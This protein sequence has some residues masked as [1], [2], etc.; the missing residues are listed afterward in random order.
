MKQLIKDFFYML[1]SVLLTAGAVTFLLGAIPMQLS[2]RRLGSLGYLAYY[3][4]YISLSL[5]IASLGFIELAIALISLSIV[6]GFNN[7]A[8]SRGCSYFTSV[9]LSVGSFVSLLALGVWSWSIYSGLNLIEKG[10]LY[11]D[12]L[13]SQLQL[14]EESREIIASADIISQLPS[15]LFVLL[16]MT[17]VVALLLEEKVCFL[18]GEKPPKRK[19]ALGE[20]KVPNFMIWFFIIF[21]FGVFFSGL[22]TFAKSISVNG[23]NILVFIYFFQ[24]LAIASKYF[25]VFRLNLVWRVLAT[26]LFV[27]YLPFLLSLIGVLDYWINFRS[28]LLKKATP[29]KERRGS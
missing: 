23:F 18:L 20:F 25:Q 27:V 29:I 24:G 15:I 6:V 3:I 13:M 2:W 4:C 28:R 5:L 12:G 19:R 11:L 8:L 1:W 22:G 26:V 16:G 17:L 14:P 9:T 21:L 10:R 7:E